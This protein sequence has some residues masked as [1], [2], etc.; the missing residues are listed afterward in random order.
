MSCGSPYLIVSK[1]SHRTPGGQ[2]LLQDVSFSLKRGSVLAIAGPNGAGKTTLL[3]LISG[4]VKPTSGEI[5]IDRK[6]LARLS[7]L[8]RARCMA[9]VS[10]QSMPDAR[11]PLKEYVALGQLPIWS[12]NSAK[13]HKDALD[14]ILEMTGL[15]DLAH[16]AMGQLSGGEKQR[17]HIARTLAQKPQLLFLDEPTNHLDPDAKGRMLSLVTAL[18]IT[19]VMVIHDLVMIPEFATHLALMKDT[20]LKAF[21]LVS[22]VQTP[23]AIRDT[24]GV[25]YRLFSH[26]ERQIP[27]LDIRK[28]TIPHERNP[29]E[30]VSE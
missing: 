17:A 16:K 27:A 19:L 30:G 24:F 7:A 9:V 2:V 13:E 15:V 29:V 12:D 26:E 8:E 20:R 3:N 5:L 21:G 28:I 22:D 6:P 10:Q 23:S 25:D 18:G 4:L 14:Q 11:L 1:L